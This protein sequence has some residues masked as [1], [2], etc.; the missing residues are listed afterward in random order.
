MNIWERQLN[1]YYILLDQ[2]DQ[3]KGKGLLRFG[4]CSVRASDVAGQY[5]CERKIEMQYIHGKV[6]T[7]SKNQGTKA[8]NTL[9]KG[10]E[11]VDQEDVWKAVYSKEPVLV[12]EWLLLAKYNGIILSGQPDCI[13]FENGSPQVIFEYKFS[14]SKRA[15]LSHHVQAG[16]YGL[17]LKYLGFNT[18]KLFYSIVVADRTAKYDQYIKDEVFDA[19]RKNPKKNSILSLKNAIIYF[20]KFDELEAQSNIDW[21]IQFWKKRREATLTN[22]SK[23][24]K[25]CEYY[26]QCKFQSKIYSF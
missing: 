26:K 5:Y 7:A 23:K 1:R 8:H 24:C 15:Y 12:S 3:R 17:L 6:K 16:F 14:K 11:A 20:N 10:V 9:L 19:V 18:E 2:I 25:I 13:F 22:N 21:A 4:R